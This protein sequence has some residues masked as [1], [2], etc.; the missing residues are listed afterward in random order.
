MR[1]KALTL[2]WM[3][4]ERQTSNLT[5][6]AALKALIDTED[7]DTDVDGQENQLHTDPEPL[8]VTDASDLHPGKFIFPG[9]LILD[10]PILYA[11][12]EL[13]NEVCH[14]AQPPMYLLSL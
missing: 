7:I 2:T 11:E 14:D 3:R 13:L 8:P 4:T 1:R 9:R 12:D 5:P 6:N 10:V